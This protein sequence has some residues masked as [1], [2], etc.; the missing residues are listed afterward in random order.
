M[1]NGLPFDDPVTGR[2][3]YD[4]LPTA[5]LEPLTMQ[6]N[7]LG[8]LDSS[9]PRIANAGNKVKINGRCA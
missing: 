9:N 7:R 6:A 4:L 3:R 5:F 2:P 8:N 1:L